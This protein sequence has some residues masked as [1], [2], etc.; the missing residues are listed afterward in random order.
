MLVIPVA[1]GVNLTFLR[2][3]KAAAV[4]GSGRGKEQLLDGRDLTTA[5]GTC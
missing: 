4:E 2:N 3:D 5:D 1:V